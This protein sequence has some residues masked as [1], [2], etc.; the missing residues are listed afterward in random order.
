MKS[1]EQFIKHDLGYVKKSWKYFALSLLT[2]EILIG[3]LLA[4]HYELRGDLGEYY[5]RFKNTL[6]MIG[7]FNV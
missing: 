6:L 1:L 7:I 5:F 4:T 2:I 3:L